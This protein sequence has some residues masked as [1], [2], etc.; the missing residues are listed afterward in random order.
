MALSNLSPI[1]RLE[2]FLNKIAG[3]SVSISAITRKEFFLN[4]IA[5]KAAN[6]RSRI[7]TLEGKNFLPTVSSS[8]SGKVA[9]VDNSGTWV[10]A[11]AS[12]GLPSY[13]GGSDAYKIL[14]IDYYDGYI[15]AWEYTARV[16]VFSEDDN[17]WTCSRSVQD[18]FDAIDYGIPLIFHVENTGLNATEWY[19]D[20]D[21]NVQVVFKYADSTKM[22][23][24]IF[25]IT[26]LDAVS[27]VSKT[28]SFTT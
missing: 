20:G 24:E 22:N 15:P 10:A 26:A 2:K 25:T 11:A 6:D 21:D 1:T 28:I 9:T 19:I 4:K 17:V 27:K 14:R 16:F 5:E 3:V 8:D 13:S 12:G 23:Y 7:T 18:V